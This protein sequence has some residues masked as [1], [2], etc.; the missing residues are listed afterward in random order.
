MELYVKTAAALYDLYS[1]GL[2]G[3]TR[4]YV[5][6]ARKSGGPV[7]EL[8]CGTGRVTVPV[9]QAGIDIVG[10]DLSEDML[11]IAREKIATLDEDARKRIKLVYGDMRSFYVDGRFT[12]AMIPYR[13]FCHLLTP[14]DQRRAL[15]R[16]HGFLEDEGRLIINIFDP[17]LDW[18]LRDS[19]FPESPMRKHNE[20]IHPET[21]NRIVIWVSRRHTLERQFIDED[22]VFEEV[23]GEGSVVSKSYAKLTLRWTYRYEMQHLLELCGYRVEALYG[24]FNRGPFRYGAEQVWV[25]RKS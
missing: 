5:E 18:I 4:F 11:S 19:E 14:E 10:V 8:A 22:R 15:E 1:L 3:D 2:T 24:D 21:G 17:R 13:S 25:A 20:F 6:E 9:A 23:D 16:I 12:L 7:L